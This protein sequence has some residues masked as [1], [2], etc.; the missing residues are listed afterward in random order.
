MLLLTGLTYGLQ[1]VTHAI[2]RVL[3]FEHN[4]NIDSLANAC[5]DDNHVAIIWRSFNE[6]AI[7]DIDRLCPEFIVLDLGRADQHTINFCCQ[8]RRSHDVPILIMAPRSDV[9]TCVYAL[10]IGAADD[11]MVWPRSPA[12]DDSL[13]LGSRTARELLARIRAH[14]RRHRG[15]LIPAPK[16]III[17]PLLIDLDR[18]SVAAH[19]RTIDLTTNEY[20]LVSSLATQPGQVLSRSQLLHIVHGNTEEAF[21]RAIDVIVSRVRA[22]IEHNAARP[23]L[24]RTVRGVGYVLTPG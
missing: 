12:L 2:I 9:D 18:R 16:P 14:V 4:A 22:K 3:G 11:Y 21:D 1:T 20:A 5:L 19:G 15:K 13:H 7:A 23:Q 17:G 8:V 24:L 10:E 6:N